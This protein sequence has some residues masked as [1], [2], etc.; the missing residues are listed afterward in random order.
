MR[1]KKSFSE[2]NV[3]IYEVDFCNYVMQTSQT[4][5]FAS[6]MGMLYTTKVTSN[7]ILLKNTKVL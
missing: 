1:Q 6:N 3:S 5:F 2:T 4:A 7:E